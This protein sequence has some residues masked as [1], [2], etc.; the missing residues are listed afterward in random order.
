MARTGAGLATTGPAPLGV[1]GPLAGTPTRVDGQ[2]ANVPVPPPAPLVR[3]QRMPVR[4]VPAPAPLRPV[5]SRK[6]H[7]VE[8]F[9]GRRLHHH[10]SI[11]RRIRSFAGILL[12]GLVVA[13]IL[14]AVIAVIVGLISIEAQHALHHG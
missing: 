8:R 3:P 12:I 1:P 5:R 6:V 13:A 14:A 4:R 9:G 10:A 11:W 7:L 2:V